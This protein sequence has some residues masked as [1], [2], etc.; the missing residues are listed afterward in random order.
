MFL[1]TLSIILNHGPVLVAEPVDES[2]HVAVG[3]MTMLDLTLT[4]LFVTA[5]VLG[6]WLIGRTPR[7]GRGD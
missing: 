6:G 2:F 1:G 3:P 7:I 4:A 5:Q